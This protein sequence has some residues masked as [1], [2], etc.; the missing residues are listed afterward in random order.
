MTEK[1]KINIGAILPI[2]GRN[3][4]YQKLEK[5]MQLA[6][7]KINSNNSI[8]PHH[9]ISVIETDGKCQPDTVMKNFI[10][11]YTGRESMVGVLGPACTDTIEPVVGLSKHFRMIVISYSAEGAMLS[12]REKYP[13]F[14]RTIGENKQYEYVYTKLFKKFN[15]KRVAALNEDGQRST[16]YISH[17]EATLKQNHIDLISNKKFPRE[18]KEGEMGKQLAD[19]K[20]KNARIIIADVDED[21]ASLVMCEAYKLQVSFRFLINYIFV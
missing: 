21:V 5:A 1:P 19:L 4:G 15:W 3:M 11:F 6:E 17:M 20:A 10:N 7:N 12:D 9:Q 14:F 8:L 18:R 13:Y 2:T 16:E